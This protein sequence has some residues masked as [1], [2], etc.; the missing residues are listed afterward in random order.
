MKI[1]RSV[2]LIS[3]MISLMLINSCTKE[4]TCTVSEKEGVKVYKNKNLPSV[5]KLDFNPVKLFEI[6]NDSTDENYISYSDFDIINFDSAGNIFIAEGVGYPR[7]NKYDRNG[8]YIKTFVK[9]GK[10]PGEVSQIFSTTIKNDTVYVGNY[11]NASILLFNTAGEFLENI[12]PEGFYAQFKPVGKD[13]FVCKTYRFKEIEGKYEITFEIVLVN[14]RFQ[15]L[16]VLDQ[17][18]FMNGDVGLPDTW[19]YIVVSKDR[20]FI[21]VNDQNIYKINVFDHEGNLIEEIYKNY[22]SIPFSV[23][24]YE[25][26]EYYLKKTNQGGIKRNMM[27][28]KRSVVGVF[29]DKN[30]NLLV[31]PAVDTSK[32]NTEGMYMD[33]FKDGVYLNS[34]MLKTDKPYYQCDFETFIHFNGD[35]MYKYDTDRNVLE[36][37]EY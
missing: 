33:F 37:Y 3:A 36:V 8:N 6:K 30:G 27:K 23:E 14:N 29:S 18:V 16:K 31:Q 4:Q 2:L 5:E 19:I 32:G 11:E 21:P 17:L 1:R 15:T 22:A 10:G 7:I 13:K 20:I 28:R 12:Q 34:Y 25:K 35:R 26:M 9:Q 24:E